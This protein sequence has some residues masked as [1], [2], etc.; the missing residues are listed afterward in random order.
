M[1]LDLY[2][3]ENDF[4]ESRNKSADAIRKGIVF[5]DGKCAMKPSFDIEENCS[6]EIK[7]D[8]CAY[9]GRGG[10]KLEKALDE[11]KIDLKNKVCVDIG[12]S[13]G[14]FTDCLL[15]NGAE[16]VYAVDS[17]KDQ[18][19]KKLRTDSR[20]VCMESFNA[21]YLTDADIGEKC[22]VVTMDVSFISQ[23]M[24]YEAVTNI[25]KIGGYFISLI[26]P[27][28]EVGKSYI[29]KNGI[30]KDEKVRKEICKKL[31]ETSEVFGLKNIEIIDS[32]ILGG[33]GN[34]EYLALFRYDGKCEE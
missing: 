34:K 5:V 14:G 17:G 19:H 27:Q 21:R 23:T 8:Y 16:K 7:G 1:R 22:D 12:S 4:F 33:D 2:L 6:V 28:F 31:C 24:L 20:V 3:T 29:G 32:P 13:T 18:L 30:V 11:F 10:L 15:Q 25:L 9:V 26:K